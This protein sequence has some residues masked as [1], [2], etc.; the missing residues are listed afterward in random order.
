MTRLQSLHLGSRQS[1]KK[2]NIVNKEHRNDLNSTTV[3][4]DSTSI[5]LPI[6]T[7]QGSGSLSEPQSRTPDPSTDYAAQ[8]KSN[9][10]SCVEEG[11]L[12]LVVLEVDRISGVQ[13]PSGEGRLL[14]EYRCGVYVTVCIER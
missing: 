1:E 11:N 5:T 7:I 13:I 12:M 6:T 10:P 8:V 2:V 4:Y 14:P 3:M 9:V